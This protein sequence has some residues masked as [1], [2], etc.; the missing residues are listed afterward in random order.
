M[1]KRRKELGTFPPQDWPKSSRP[2]EPFRAR[3]IQVVETHDE[4]NQITRAWLLEKMPEMPETFYVLDPIYPEL[5]ALTDLNQF[6]SFVERLGL[7]EFVPLLG[8]EGGV[9]SETVGT[10]A[11]ARDELSELWESMD[12]E[13]QRI[14]LHNTLLTEDRRE[15]DSLDDRIAGF[16]AVA[17]GDPFS[18]T[19]LQVY[20]RR[21][22]TSGILFER[23]VHILAR[24]WIEVSE[25]VE[26]TIVCEF[27]GNPFRPNRSGQRFCPGR[28]CNQRAHRE[29]YDKSE[30][31][32]AYQRMYG[33][34]RRGSMTADEFEDWKRDNKLGSMASTETA[35]ETNKKSRRRTG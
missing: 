26:D 31:R 14:I 6:V 13:W 16:A 27:C 28:D 18:R 32:R 34:K 33:R 8:V 25:S 22:S 15:G 1:R 4:V 24:G 29:A 35:A 5:L 11:V 10:R 12:F 19:M 7:L 17:T 9:F 2:R 20:L 21:E 23:P 3:P 30:Y